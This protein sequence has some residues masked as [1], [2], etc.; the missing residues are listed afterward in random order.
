[1]VAAMKASQFSTTHYEASG[2]NGGTVTAIATV[3]AN[4]DMWDG[5][6]KIYINS[7]VNADDARNKLI[8]EARMLIDDLSMPLPVTPATPEHE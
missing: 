1:M 3:T 8:A 5:S 2:G 4:G 6:I 7:A